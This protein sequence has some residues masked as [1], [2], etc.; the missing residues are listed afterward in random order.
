MTHPLF[1][2]NYIF[3]GYPF[4]GDYN[5]YYPGDGYVY[6]LRGSRNFL[7]GNLSQLQQ[8]GWIDRKTRAIFVE[9]SAYNPNIN[10]V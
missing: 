9:F 4:S 6:E 10:M 7:R 5:N 2:L 3:L 8:L 1:N